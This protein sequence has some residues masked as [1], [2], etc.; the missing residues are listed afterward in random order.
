MPSNAELERRKALLRGLAEQHHAQAIAA[1]PLPREALT[2]LFDHLDQALGA[3]CDHSLRFTRQFLQ[4]QALD[5][6]T[7]VPW[8]Q[9]N[10]GYCDC[11]VLAN[12]ED[13]WQ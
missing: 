3:A 9:A 4:Q 6:A 5:E 11:E 13:A 12:V 7:V 1:L 8:L 2:A 10:G